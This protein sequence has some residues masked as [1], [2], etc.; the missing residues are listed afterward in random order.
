MLVEV[1]GTTLGRSGS[2]SDEWGGTTNPGDFDVDLIK[3]DCRRYGDLD[4]EGKG[5]TTVE[6]EKRGRGVKNTP[7]LDRDGGGTGPRCDVWY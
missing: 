7:A 4:R 3:Q 1:G 5:E 6:H 2:I